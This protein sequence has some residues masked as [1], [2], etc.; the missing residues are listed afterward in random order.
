MQDIRTIFGWYFFPQLESDFLGILRNLE[1]NEKLKF[2]AA[3]TNNL[4]LSKWSAKA[5]KILNFIKSSR[6]ADVI[7]FKIEYK[8]ALEQAYKEI[9][10]KGKYLKNID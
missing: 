5:V 8:E 2:S 10:D 3:V 1:K 9:N 7:K 4:F 6:N